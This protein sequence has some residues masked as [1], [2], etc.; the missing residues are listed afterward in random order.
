MQAHTAENTHSEVTKAPT[1]HEV[2]SEL[3]LG[4]KRFRKGGSQH[5]H[6]TLDDVRRLQSA[7]SPGVLVLTCADSRVDPTVIFDR[8][9]G[10]QF[11]LRV[12]GNIVTQEILGSIQYA[13]LHL[14]V[15]A[16]VVLGHDQCG[17]VKAALGE[18][19][20][21]SQHEPKELEAILNRIRKNVPVS[22]RENN[23]RDMDEKTLEAASAENARQTAA[24]IE[25]ALG[26]LLANRTDVRVLSALYHLESGNVFFE[27]KEI[28][29][30]R[31][32][33]IGLGMSKRS[34]NSPHLDEELR[35]LFS[36]I[37]SVG[38]ELQVAAEGLAEGIN[39]GKREQ[40]K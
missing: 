35:E 20:K 5:P 23:W 21:G 11:V 6:Q 32:R 40:R 25:K 12:A 14:G 36:Q 26:K 18:H 4:N 17:A 15:R 7:Q 9:L 22:W 29:R 16:I 24:N 33:D 37:R 3:D 34:D 30:M 8:G 28:L 2:L 13:V 1:V 38:P 39:E 27:D 31:A 10:D 19:A